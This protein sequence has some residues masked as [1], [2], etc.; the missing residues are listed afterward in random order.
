[1]CR[2]FTFSQLSPQRSNKCG[3]CINIFKNTL[4]DKIYASKHNEMSCLEVLTLALYT[5]PVNSV[6]CTYVKHRWYQIYKADYCLNSVRK[7]EFKR[8]NPRIKNV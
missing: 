2:H 1:M 4:L 7:L 8:E 6:H 3:I 5:V